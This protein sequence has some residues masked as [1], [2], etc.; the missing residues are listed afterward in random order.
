LYVGIHRKESELPL[1]RPVGVG[2]ESLLTKIVIR[3]TQMYKGWT[4]R[5]F[6]VDPGRTSVC[7]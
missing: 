5:S 4:K 6:S 3:N 7:H 2:K 1:E